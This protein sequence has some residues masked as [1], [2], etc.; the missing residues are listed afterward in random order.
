M[1]HD[2][3][4]TLADTDAAGVVYFA[5]LLSICHEAYEASLSEA[6]IDLKAFFRDPSVAIPIAQAEIQFFQP[7]FCGDHIQIYL[8]PHLIKDSEFAV[9]YRIYRG[10]CVDR[11]VGQAKTRHVCIDPRLRQRIP[12]PE[13]IQNWLRNVKIEEETD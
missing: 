6:N 7:L 9:E 2:R 10:D 4:L 12:L 13:S 11:L 8:T 3:S 1:P 5:R